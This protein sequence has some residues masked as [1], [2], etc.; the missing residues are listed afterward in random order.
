MTNYLKGNTPATIY[1]QLIAVGNAADHAGLT[2]TLKPV[3]TDDG[4]GGA[5]ASSLSL[6]TA[7]TRVTSN[8]QLQFGD[9]GTYVYQSSDGILAIVADGEIDLATAT[10]DINATTACEIDNT[11]TSNGVKF[12]TNVSGM[13][14]TIGHTTSETTVNDN[15]T[16][17][18]TSALNDVIT[19]ATGKKLQFVDSGE[20]LSGDG[21]DLTIGSSGDISLTPTSNVNIVGSSKKLTFAGNDSNYVSVDG[22]NQMT[23]AAAAKIDIT[24]AAASTWQ[25]SDGTLT[26]YANGADDKVLIKGDNASGVA[27]EVLAN[28][29]DGDVKITAGATSG[30]LDVDGYDL[31]MDIGA[32]GIDI[33]STNAIDID[34]SGSGE[35]IN[36]DAQAG[37]IYIDSG[38]A[39]AN[40]IKINASNS[41]SST[42]LNL[43][44]AGT[45]VAAIDINSSG[46]I[47][48][49]CSTA[50]DIDSTTGTTLDCTTLSI[51]STD[52][53]NLTMTANAASTK[54]LTF[55]ATNSHISGQSDIHI[56]ADGDI[57]LKSNIT[58]AITN[59]A[60]ATTSVSTAAGIQ[61]GTDLSGVDIVIGHTTSDVLIA[62]NLK[63]QGDA[64][65]TGTMTA[66]TV[67]YAALTVSHATAT[68]VT[69]DNQEH[70]DS[71]NARDILFKFTGEKASGASVD[72]MAHILVAHD[73]SSADEKGYI[74]FKCN[75]G[76]EGTSPSSALKLSS[77]ATAT[78]SG[79][80]AAGTN[81]ITCGQLNADNIRLDGN[82]MTSTD[83]NGDLTLTP[84][85]TGGVALIGASVGG[86]YSVAGGSSASAS[87]NYGV[88]LGASCTA[89][90]TNAISIG[91]NS[92]ASATGSV[93]LGSYCTSSG[94]TAIALGWYAKADKLGEISHSAG[95]N[96]A[97]GDTRGSFFHTF[98]DITM[99]SSWQ[100]LATGSGTSGG[101]T[102]DDDTVVCG[103]IVVVGSTTGA[104][105]TVG[106]IIEFIAENDGGTYAIVGT[107]V[108]RTHETEDTSLN[109][110][111]AVSSSKLYVQV[112]D[113]ASTPT[114]R[115]SAHWHLV[116]HTY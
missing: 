88:A 46:G 93:T 104:A 87:G 94:K 103:N 80:I 65:I 10:I 48:I 28:H 15:I 91:D 42:T 69:L 19:V 68:V 109:C 11:N 107:P 61:I 50:L 30:I 35:D 63:V 34:T 114:M 45:G 7:A 29:V 76:S 72:D 86:D 39:V 71:D 17:T 116:Q 98:D 90:G 37:S 99:S 81:A 105:V 101:I 111:V 56:D 5:T 57:H 18:G 95:R 66:G 33:L 73:G 41:N 115:W 79:A 16:V 22:S 75:A 47:N 9:T 23:V 13:P 100:N 25:T 20:Y 89:S 24:A 112:T 85:G 44:S 51:D 60:S 59:M 67:S 96:A 55:S 3:F 21:T 74:D 78:F 14:I 40:A 70:S 36:I 52:T 53:T 49:G 4:S 102:F 62:D 8:N 12:G 64:Y 82:T 92:T 110:Q 54:V 26:I 27:V 32:G 6:S 113:S 108:V 1:K 77:D 2:A 83:S 84:N 58:G 97:T 31:D 38:E 43:T 106:Y